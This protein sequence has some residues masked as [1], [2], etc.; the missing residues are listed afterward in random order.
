[1]EK[2]IVAYCGDSIFS[3]WELH[4]PQ[5]CDLVVNKVERSMRSQVRS[6]GDEQHISDFFSAVQAL[7]CLYLVLVLE[8]GSRLLREVEPELMDSLI[9]ATK[10][11]DQTKFQSLSGSELSATEDVDEEVEETESEDDEEARHNLTHDSED[12]TVLV[13]RWFDGLINKDV[14]ISKEIYSLTEFDF[15]RQELRILVRKVQ[16][17]R[18]KGSNS[19][20]E[21]GKVNRDIVRAERSLTRFL[22][23]LVKQLH[24]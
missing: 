17:I 20:E 11:G 23:D 3:Y 8:E 12:V 15:D 1:M 4:N 21:E 22:R 7:V 5:L 19:D 16:S 13:D 9:Q 14:N 18:E 24:S 10:D 2:E 6:S